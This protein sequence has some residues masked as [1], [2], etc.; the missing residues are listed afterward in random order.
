MR[1]LAGALCAVFLLTTS[2]RASDQS[3]AGG[4]RAAGPIAEPQRP[5]HFPCKKR[6]HLGRIFNSCSDK[7]GGGGEGDD[8]QL[9]PS[10]SGPSAYPNNLTEEEKG[11][12][13]DAC[14]A[15]GRGLEKTCFASCYQ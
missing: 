3:G 9:S 8:F 10:H 1:Y 4:N 2:C 12:C 15:G 7:T 6:V 5:R 11:Q 13:Y 14:V